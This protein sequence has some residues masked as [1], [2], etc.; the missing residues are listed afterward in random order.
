M[1]RDPCEIEVWSEQ[2]R[3]GYDVEADGVLVP[4]D[5]GVRTLARGRCAAMLILCL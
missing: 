3:Q 5:R 2:L 4:L 1:D